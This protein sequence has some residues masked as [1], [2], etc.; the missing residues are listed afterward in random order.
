MAVDQRIGVFTTKMRTEFQV[1]YQ[2]TAVPAKFEKIT[3]II[4]S[5]ARIEHYTWM[6]PSPGLARYQGYRRFGKI[7][8]V[9]YSVENKEFDASFEVLRRDIED[10]QTGGYELKPKELAE[11]A[12]LFPGRWALKTLALGTTYTCFDGSAFFANSHTIG[13]GDNLMTGTGTANS[14]GLTY[15]MILL[16][17]GGPLKPL[18]YQARKEPAFRTDA[19]SPQ[20]DLAKTIKYW[21]DME[22]EAAYGYWWD[23]VHYTW[24]N[25]PSVTDMHNAFDEITSTMRGFRLP[26]STSSEDGEYIHEQTDFNSGNFTAVVTPRIERTTFNALNSEWIP[27]VAGGSANANNNLYKGFADV[28]TTNYLA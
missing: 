2:A 1:A 12:K 13:T 8:T 7:D 17:N 21:I 24:T 16:Y 25:L 23:A 26:R 3:Q 14:D 11:R 10:D 18:I 19:G 5:S 27:V 6:S 20:S 9:K 22:G 28:I 15:K 4:P